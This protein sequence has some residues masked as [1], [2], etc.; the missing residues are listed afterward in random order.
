LAQVC[1]L[2]VAMAAEMALAKEAREE[3]P[4][5][6]RPEYAEAEFWD[7]RFEHNRTQ[8]D[9]YAQWDQMKRVVSKY[10]PVE[11]RP[12]TLMVGCGN[13]RLSE[14]MF[15]FGGYRDMVNIDISS[16][17][18]EQMREKHADMP[19]EWHVM[20]ATATT[21]EDGS[22]D[23]AVDKGTFDAITCEPGEEKPLAQA[24]IREMARVVKVGGKLVLV[25][26]ASHRQQFITAVAP[27]WDLEEVVK[28]DLSANATL[29]NILRSR[30]AGAPMSHALK[31]PAL[32]ISAIKEFRQVTAAQKVRE[33]NEHY[34]D[35]DEVDDGDAKR[36]LAA[37][38]KEVL[39]QRKAAREAKVAEAAAES[40]EAAA[41]E[42]FA[43]APSEA[44]V[45]AGEAVRSPAK[46]EETDD[47]HAEAGTSTGAGDAA[48]VD[49]EAYAKMARQNFCYL[50]V[51][52]REA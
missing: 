21:F 25:S 49:K 47:A 10:S 8:Y 27:C 30:L 33:M 4:E 17:A 19:M 5:L 35:T 51:F 6:G 52:T 13:S 48:A 3:A 43:Q 12:R 32:F 26:H 9:W 18:I 16:V 14:E 31:D 42:T 36:F 11:D 41:V 1:R 34:E 22:F 39:Q 45:A 28:C 37:R 46:G 15:M 44:A 2:S 40:T 7:R 24:L 29:V 23:L 38:L 20:D 50:Y